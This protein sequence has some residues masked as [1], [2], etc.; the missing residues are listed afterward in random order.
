MVFTTV[1][2]EADILQNKRPHTTKTDNLFKK[3]WEV[4]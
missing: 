4:R 1:N 3:N 2:L